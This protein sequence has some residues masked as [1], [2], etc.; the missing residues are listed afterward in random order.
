[1]KRFLPHL[2]MCLPARFYF[3]TR[4]FEQGRQMFDYT[5]IASLDGRPFATLQDGQ[6]LIHERPAWTVDDIRPLVEALEDM[7]QYVF[8]MFPSGNQVPEM[9]LNFKNSENKFDVEA[10]AWEL[11]IDRISTGYTISQTVAHTLNIAEFALIVKTL[12]VWSS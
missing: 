2:D 12:D 7:L 11:E 1:M 5:L 9:V 8:L 3:L 6:I 10:A 4:S